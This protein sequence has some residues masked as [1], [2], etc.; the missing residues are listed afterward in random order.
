M[1]KNYLKIAWRNL[2]KSKVYSA[3]NIVGLAVGMAVAILISLWVWDEL[4]YNKQFANYNHIVRVYENSTHSGITNTFNSM[5]IP[6]ANE[7]R[8]KYGSDFMRVAL[9]SWE[10][11]NI[12]AYNNKKLSLNGMFAQPDFPAIFSLKMVKGNWHGIDDPT[13]IILNESTARALFGDEDPMGKVVKISNKA[14]LKVSGIFADLPYNGEF[15][16]VKYLVPW[17]YYENS[18]SWV[19][20]DETEWDDNSFQIYAQLADNTIAD[21]VGA[22]VR[23][24]LEGHN[25]ND[26]PEVLLH[27]M[28]KWHLY[29][30]FKDGKNT[31]GNIEF[32]WMF[33]LI[34]FFVLLLACINF[35][36]L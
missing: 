28:A 1:L 32:V 10:F 33:G 25:R 21:K 16:D 27:P 36:N 22:K 8:T 30:E 31:G 15:R 14:N 3:I 20:R 5:P 24:A 4:S 19:K 11:S 23:K 18:E 17:Q 34:G 13:S 29:G 12:L 35:M 2:I 9:C 7:F 6:L 26:K